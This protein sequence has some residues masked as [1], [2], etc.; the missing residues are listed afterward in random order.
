MCSTRVPV[1]TIVARC[2]CRQRILFLLVVVVMEENTAPT[3]G[4]R[5]RNDEHG[6]TNH[7]LGVVTLKHKIDTIGGDREGDTQE[8]KEVAD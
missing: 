8:L 1:I 4:D 6:K 7:G 2:G 5:S 3:A